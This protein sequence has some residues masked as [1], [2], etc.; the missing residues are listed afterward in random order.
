VPLSRGD[1]AD[2]GAASQGHH[3]PPEEGSADV[4]PH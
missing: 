4:T 2:P 1:F 3:W